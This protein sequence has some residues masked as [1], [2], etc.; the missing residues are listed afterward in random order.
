M[1]ELD[2]GGLSVVASPTGTQES[3]PT[4]NAALQLADSLRETSPEVNDLVGQVGGQ[5][6]AQAEARAQQDALKGSATNYADAVKSGTIQGGQNPWYVQAYNQDSAKIG[7]QEA[8]AKVLAD[9][10]TWAERG[11]NDGGAAYEARLSKAFADIHT[12]GNGTQMNPIDYD[13]GFQA[14]AQPIM[15]Q[16]IAQNHAYNI[17]RITQEGLQAASTSVALTIGNVLKGSPNASPED[18]FKALES[19]H[20]EQ[21]A[22]GR[23]DPQW[24]DLVFQGIR[25]AANTAL[26]PSILNLAKAPYA[27]GPPLASIS[28]LDGKPNSETLNS[29]AFWIQRAADSLGNDSVKGHARQVFQEGQTVYQAALKQFGYG[30]YDGTVTGPQLMEFAKAQGISPEGYA[31]GAE[32]VANLTKGVTGLQA[33]EIKLQGNS[34]PGTTEKLQL[35]ADMATHGFT[36]ANTARLQRDVASGLISGD[37][38]DAMLGHAASTSRSLMEQAR[39]D[40]RE[41]TSNA[42]FDISQA[43]QFAHD[44][45]VQGRQVRDD[46]NAQA[47]TSLYAA[48]AT[49][50]LSGSGKAKLETVGNAAHDAWLAGHSGD[51]EGASK[52]QQQALARYALPIIQRYTKTHAAPTSPG[53][54]PGGNTLR[55]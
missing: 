24:K 7:T 42:H 23:T 12:Q 5:L 44:A 51:Y 36:Q 1:A 49:V 14:G 2:P 38:A 15:E 4:N 9:S 13:K 47:I 52:A 54:S 34:V 45:I 22:I 43:R 20:Q 30:L 32:Q 26:D 6:K 11:L 25:S 27:G 35:T 16:A 8:G 10:Q 41:A 55:N 21:T 28:G 50:E 46:N 39:S 29:D 18:V 19:V 17:Q 3:G 48:G 53:T 33:D 37:Q 40:R 31:A